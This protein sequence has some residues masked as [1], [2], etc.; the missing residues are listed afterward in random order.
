MHNSIRFFIT[1]IF[2]NVINSCVAQTTLS[3]G[4]IAT[5]ENDIIYNSVPSIS[6]TPASGAYNCFAEGFSY[7]WE[8][9]V[10][11][12]GWE[13]IGSGEQYPAG[14]PAIV[15]STQIRRKVQCHDV[16]AYSN[17]LTFAPLYVSSTENMNYVRVNTITVKN[18]NLW[19]EAIQLPIGNKFQTTTYLDGFQR[20]IQEVI[21]G[22]SFANGVQKDIVTPIEYDETGKVIKSYLPYVTGIDI[23]SF[24]A[25]AVVAQS[26]YINSIFGE[27]PSYS[28][29]EYENSPLNRIIKSMQAGNSWAGSNVGVSQDYDINSGNE[30]VHIWQIDFTSGAVPATSLTSVYPDGQLFKNVTTDENGKKVIT[31][32]D[33]GGNTILKKVQLSNTPAI[34]HAGWLCTYYVYDDFGRQRFI[35]PPKAVV[36]LDGNN[37]VL[38]ADVINELCF[39]NEYDKRGRLVV[40]KSPGAEPVYM[41][42]DK[43]D[44]LIFT[45]DGNQRLLQSPKKW[46]VSLYDNLDRV[47]LTGLMEYASGR[48]DLQ[49][50][51]DNNTTENADNNSITVATNVIAP[52]DL[53]IDTRDPVNAPGTYTATGS[54]IFLPGFSSTGSNDNFVAEINPA[55]Q[56]VTNTSTVNNNPLPA[57]NNLYTLSLSFYDD[58][59]YQGSKTFSTNFTIDNTV[60]TNET[61]AVQ[62]SLLTR[63]FV[64]G[65]KVRLL[66][67]SNT[68][69]TTTSFYDDKGR[70]IQLDGENHK[71]F[72]DE[73]TTQF[74]FSGKV[75]SA[76]EATRVTDNTGIK[77]FTKNTYDVI[78]R[79]TAISKSINGASEKTI[80]SYTYN[81]L[82][83]LANKKLAPGFAGDDGPQL[84][85]IDYT[86]NTHGS[87]LGINKDYSTSGTREGH[88]F[89]M[90]LGYDKAGTHGF[91]TQ[92]NGNIAGNAWK[93]RG[94]NTIRKYDYTYDNAGQLLTATFNQRN[95]TTSGWSADKM[96]F[97]SNYSY[98]ENG[99][100]KTQNQWGVAPG[101][102]T[103]QIDALVYNYDIVSGGWT[104]KLK[105]IS[106]NSLATTNG[107]LGDFKNGTVGASSQQY[108]Y[109]KNAN[110]IKDLNKEVGD[111]GTAGIQYNF[112][113][114]P[115]LITFKNTNKTIS[116]IYDAAG[117]KL[118]KILNEP[119]N[120]GNLARHVETDYVNDF[121]YENNELQF[122]SHEE[123]RVRI[124]TPFGNAN[125]ANYD[126]GGI[127]MPYGKQGVFD[128]FI[129]DHLTN[130]RMILTEEIKRNGDIATMEDANANVKQY[131]E[132]VFGQDGS[133]NEVYVT[134]NDKP[135]DPCNTSSNSY[136]QGWMSN[137]SAKVS[138][139]SNLL[140]KVGP[141]VILKV[142]SGDKISAQADY[143]YKTNNPSTSGTNTVVSDI[144]TTLLGA[145]GSDKANNIVKGS[146]T[147]IQ[148]NLN[149][150][151]GLSNFITDRNQNPN[152][153]INTSAPKGYLNFI[154][155][156]EQFNYVS[157][158]AIVDR[159]KVACDDAR[160]PLRIIRKEAIKNGWVFVYLSNESDEPVYFDNFSVSHEK[161]RILE[162]N[163]YYSYGLKINAISSRAQGAIL[164][165]YGYQGDFAENDPET[166]L[167]EF[168]LRHY[169]PQIGRWTTTDPYEQFANPYLGMGNNPIGSVDPDGGGLNDYYRNSA[170][171]IMW[172][173]STDKSI[174]WNGDAWTNIGKDYWGAINEEGTWTHWIEG[175]KY[176]ML[177]TLESPSFFINNNISCH[178]DYTQIRINNLN[179]LI[180]AYNSLDREHGQVDL[181]Q[182]WLA[183]QIFGRANYTGIDPTTGKL[184]ED[185]PV[186]NDGYLTHK[187]KVIGASPFVLFSPAGELKALGG[188]KELQE[189]NGSFSIASWKGYP[190]G[191]PKPEGTFRL[192]EGDEYNASRKLANSTNAAIRRLN[193]AMYEGLQIHEIKPVK[194]GGS[195]TSLSNKI[196]LSQEEHIKITNYW[197]SLM[198]SNK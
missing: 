149:G 190:E 165:K 189:L 145:I 194:F 97:T 131:E 146:S 19:H 193:P 118:R 60:P 136:S 3:P 148:S 112:M 88:Y 154:F 130:V 104:N 191:I 64:T 26:Q 76:Y 30:K 63:G 172:S 57:N 103:Q 36:Y 151:N 140:H 41:V 168:D 87:L 159:V 128:Y 186:G 39:S 162:E 179:K 25:N 65:T 56:S 67:G 106:E 77:V 143:Y 173:V 188:V 98:D 73:S 183:G 86:Y 175:G 177:K 116:Y 4:T 176:E 38:S 108:D 27:T 155:F 196:A 83:Q 135:T 8:R 114:L 16:V 74:D 37:W 59:S 178:G 85:S 70:A 15:T 84:E 7:T 161:G 141:N 18:I 51:V 28:V 152:S 22:G 58:Y 50:W 29:I 123:G 33:K 101:T 45:Q 43:R 150:V 142:M 119:A 107:K 198:R 79:G 48:D 66:D 68:F 158:N 156:D 111:A 31:Y 2:I 197:N 174:L 109:D 71:G 21:T 62:R 195:P 115:T 124:I 35:I 157:E 46:T 93:T 134:R 144:V 44:R 91:T 61:E 187:P 147:P 133:E 129:K 192:I 185:A 80:A 47:T 160:D 11:N 102:G 23:G 72:T 180:S 100:I 125:E 10:L 78:G 182:S 12:Q 121:V 120:G 166:E 137:T 49:T 54:I 34:E 40:K 6:T 96:N 138:K 163:H 170:G 153:N 132:G 95:I 113:N 32:T 184:I 69:L 164:N 53:V 117:N 13:I 92:L 89:G 169:D 181:P 90:E 167:D 17:I 126:G 122:F 110:T 171:Q 99:N 127:A 55:L 1:I 5:S 105:S 75:R 14:A 52:V 9:L 20:K 42:Y 82:G 81:E 139:L 24:K 94:D